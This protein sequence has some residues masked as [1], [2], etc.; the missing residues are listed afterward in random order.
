MLLNEFLS[1]KPLFYN[2]IDYD[3]MPDCWNSI[4]NGFKKPKK[5]IH[6]IGTNGKGSTGRFLAT[7]LKNMGFR[8]GHYSSPHIQ[9]FNE[10]IWLN[11]RDVNDEEL[12]KAHK[13]LQN[14]I[15]KKYLQSLSYF[16]YTTLLAMRCF[17]GFDYVVL[18]AGLGGEKDA[19]SVFDRDLT[20]VTPIDFD[21]QSFLGNS[22][23][24][25]ATT[26]LNSIKNRA[27]IGKQLHNEVYE[28]TERYPFYRDYFD[29]YEIK[30]IREFV[31]KHGFAS[32]LEDNLI[33]ALSCI[34]DEEL[35]FNLK[36]LKGIKKQLKGRLEKIDDNIFIDVGHN[37][38]AARVIVKEFKNRKIDLV[39]NTY[40]DKNYRE[41]LT[42]LKPII[43]KLF[44]ID[45]QNSRIADI[46]E[47]IAV[48]KEL[49]IEVEKY[50][51]VRDKTTLVF[52][53]FSVIEKFLNE[54]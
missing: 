49:G 47:V 42:I 33:L 50:E 28:L 6:I 7:Y 11:G 30:E 35:E 16:E 12:E 46:D 52:G 26:K 23:K 54:K 39:Y 27:I 45:V 15:S 18:E 10:R 32:Y 22:I 5:I 1:Q 14:S 24:E 37:P 20:L 48:A 3:R 31:K 53:S 43:D 44:I 40:E 29:N 34:V 36:Y 19:T 38:L 4:K 13:F 21:H 2:E 41:I 51:K 17:D 9:K 8:V 25:I